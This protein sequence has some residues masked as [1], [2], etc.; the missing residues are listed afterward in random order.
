MKARRN[1]ASDAYDASF[2]NITH[3][4]LFIKNMGDGFLV[5]H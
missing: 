1:D 5:S 3:S 4:L 2:I